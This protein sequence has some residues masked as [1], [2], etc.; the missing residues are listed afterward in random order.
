MRC[1]QSHGNLGPLI[2]GEISLEERNATI[3]HLNGCAECASQYRGLEIL[4]RRLLAG[5][6]PM[7]RAL[8]YRVRARIALEAA[9]L[10]PTARPALPVPNREPPARRA[11]TRAQPWLRQ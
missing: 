9:E 1:D 3:A 4:R 5:R 7:P 2:D 11:F 10:D 6:M 8:I